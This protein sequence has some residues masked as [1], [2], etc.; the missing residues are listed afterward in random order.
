MYM[1]WHLCD[2]SNLK[3]NDAIFIAH[4]SKH[5]YTEHIGWDK[6][7]SARKS[8]SMLSENTNDVITVKDFA[9]FVTSLLIHYQAVEFIQKLAIQRVKIVVIHQITMTYHRSFQDAYVSEMLLSATWITIK[10]GDAKSIEAFENRIFK[11]LIMLH[12][13]IINMLNGSN[14]ESNYGFD[15]W[16]KHT[17]HMRAHSIYF[18]YECISISYLHD[19]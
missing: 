15:Q 8:N 16:F 18:E 14:I 6:A 10:H 4:C 11:M 12:T 2:S 9:N 5:T 3:R 7:V 17:L 1:L 19:Y 13:S